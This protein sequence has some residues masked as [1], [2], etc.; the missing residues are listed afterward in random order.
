LNK[1]L[2][3]IG[4]NREKTVVDGNGNTISDSVLLVN[5]TSNVVVKGFTFQNCHIGVFLLLCNLS[6]I[7][8]N[9]VRN[10]SWF[11]MWIYDSSNNFI[12]GNVIENDNVGIFLS[13][14][15]HFLTVNNI[16]FGNS[17][18]NNLQA[19]IRVQGVSNNSFSANWIYGNPKGIELLQGDDNFVEANTFQDNKAGTYLT[20][21]NDNTFFH[22][23]YI[24]NTENVVV[25]QSFWDL[26]SNNWDNNYPLGGNYWSNH[27]RT[28][29]FSGP[30]QNEMGSDGIADISYMIDE[31]NKDD[32][33]LTTP[34]VSQ[35]MSVWLFERDLQLQTDYADLSHAYDWLL[36]NLT[37]LH[38]NYRDL[39]EASDSLRATHN[40][41]INELDR[42][43]NLSYTLTVMTTILAGAT[44]MLAI[45]AYRR[46]HTINRVD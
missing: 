19:G 16:I 9:R 33:P 2:S 17:F 38:V 28:D 26:S 10:C 44:I 11:G 23:N 34:F 29:F 4:E 46:R 25:N 1:C 36:W 43:R 3:L 22:N 27:N 20:E 30:Y 42:L 14:P 31:E 37:Q 5:R 8:D 40:A 13:A 35:G 6:R 39:Q 7:S 24:N 41:T 18:Y 32:Y 21:S 12:D 45:V 15:P